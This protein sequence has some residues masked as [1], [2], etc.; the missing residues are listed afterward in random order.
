[1]LWTM[2]TCVAPSTR[3]PSSPAHT[4]F[5]AACFAPDKSLTIQP[6]PGTFPRRSW[7]VRRSRALALSPGAILPKPLPNVVR[8]Y[9]Q[10]PGYR[11]MHER[12]FGERARSFANEEFH[13]MGHGGTRGP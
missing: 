12:H 2:G 9:P 4:A 10:E 11:V 7:Y 8:S 5:V 6:P 3:Y 13:A 1:M